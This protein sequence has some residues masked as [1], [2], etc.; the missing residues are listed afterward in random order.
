MR[1]VSIVIPVF[2]T[3]ASFLEEAVASALAQTHPDIELVI[4]D[5]G[6]T[7]EETLNLLAELRTKENIR[8]LHQAN[9][10]PSVAR[11]TGIAAATG[12][13]ILPLDADDLIEPSYVKQAYDLLEQNPRIGIVY[14]LADFIGAQTGPW[15]LTPYS[16]PEILLGNCIFCTAMFR[17]SDWESVGGYK[18][19]MRL[20]WEDYEFFLSLIEKGCWVYRIPQVL[21]HYRKHGQSRSSDTESNENMDIMWSDIRRYHRWLYFKNFHFLHR[22]HAGMYETWKRLSFLGK[23]RELFRL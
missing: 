10:G 13:Y 4:V 14:C 11:N 8:V 9:Q 12:D 6:S 7:R 20:G 17:K 21:F 2:N 5:D 22:R 3:D 15:E 16:Y 1:R 18:T 19:V 23:C